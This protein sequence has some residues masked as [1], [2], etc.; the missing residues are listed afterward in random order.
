MLTPFM[1]NGAFHSAQYG[2]WSRKNVAKVP[3]S[4]SLT[5]HTAGTGPHWDERMKSAEMKDVIKEI[6]DYMRSR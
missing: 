6:Q 5:Y 2:Y 3:S 1:E 4:R